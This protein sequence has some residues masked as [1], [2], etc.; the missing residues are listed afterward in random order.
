MF[1]GRSEA[2]PEAAQITKSISEGDCVIT[3]ASEFALQRDTSTSKWY[4][5]RLTKY[6]INCIAPLI[7]CCSKSLNRSFR[8]SIISSCRRLCV[9]KHQSGLASIAPSSD[10]KCTS[11]VAISSL[12]HAMSRDSGSKLGIL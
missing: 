6:F 4:V 12:L 11:V 9:V 10:L 7:R 5:S 2:K 3:S 8:P 1:A